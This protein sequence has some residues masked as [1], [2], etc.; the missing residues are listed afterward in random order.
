MTTN[1]PFNYDKHK[2]LELPKKAS[3]SA[4]MPKYPMHSHKVDVIIHN[5]PKK[6]NC[7]FCSL[8]SK[9]G[10]P[11]TN[12]EDFA[13]KEDEKCSININNEGRLE[14]GIEVNGQSYYG[15]S[16]KLKCCPFCKR[17]LK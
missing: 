9:E 8:L 5:V 16:I 7:P 1:A 4:P 14:F 10:Y 3:H 13:S 17:E 11:L 6:K 12:G 2:K 15:A